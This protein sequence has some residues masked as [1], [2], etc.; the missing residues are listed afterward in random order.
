MRRPKWTSDDLTP[1]HPCARQP[2]LHRVL[3]DCPPTPEG[4]LS[5]SDRYGLLTVTIPRKPSP[6]EKLRADVLPPEPLDIWRAEIRALRACVDLWD[7]IASGN[8]E[9]SAALNRK[10]AEKLAGARFHLMACPGEGRFLLAYRPYGW[11]MPY[12]SASLK[13]S[14]AAS[15]A[16]AARRRSAA[17][18][19]SRAPPGA[20]ASTARMPARIRCFVRNAPALPPLSISNRR[21]GLDV[22]LSPGSPKEPRDEKAHHQT[23]DAE[24]Q[25]QQQLECH[26]LRGRRGKPP[27]IEEQAL[28]VLSEPENSRII[29]REE[30]QRNRWLEE[31][32]HQDHQAFQAESA[33]EKNYR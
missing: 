14:P 16:F 13:R 31:P 4:I 29:G 25:N 23:F 33:D 20:I 30:T 7:S 32:P 15:S 6:G 22:P 9:A 24:P 19:C 26:H 27:L 17:G 8:R 10:L 11:S 5:L 28:G 3:A 21:L 2:C 1:D 12:G 18:G